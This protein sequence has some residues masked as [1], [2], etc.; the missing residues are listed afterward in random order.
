LELI[1][2]FKTSSGIENHNDIL[3]SS[4]NFISCKSFTM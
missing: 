1:V 3:W 2:L 4:K